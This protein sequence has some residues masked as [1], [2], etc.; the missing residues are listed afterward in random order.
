MDRL[1]DFFFLLFFLSLHTKARSLLNFM[2]SI[3]M[4]GMTIVK[5]SFDFTIC[6]VVLYEKWTISRPY[7]FCH[8]AGRIFSHANTW[9]HS[10]DLPIHAHDFVKIAFVSIK[11]KKTPFIW[12]NEWDLLS[13]DRVVYRETLSPFVNHTN[14]LGQ[15]TL[16]QKL[17]SSRPSQFQHVR[18][19]QKHEF[20]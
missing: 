9:K 13:C 5:A 10:Y 20:F 6:G 17:V 1:I 4:K 14:V 7:L 16:Y 8:F 3:P 18:R 15:F 11:N 19:T 2:L 12:P